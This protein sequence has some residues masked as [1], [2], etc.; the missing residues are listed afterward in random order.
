MRFL[1]LE[2]LLARGRENNMKFHVYVAILVVIMGCSRPGESES[3][4]STDEPSPPPELRAEVP[5][6]GAGPDSIEFAG[7]N[8][9]RGVRV[10][11]P[12]NTPGYVLFTPF[13][14]DITYLV[15]REGRV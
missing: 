5:D 4:P 13:L 3:M 12:T 6:G 15:D 2:G 14:S 9:P 1:R 11:K 8:E 7:L 10:N